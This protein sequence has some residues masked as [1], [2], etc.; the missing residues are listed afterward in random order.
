MGAVPLLVL[1]LGLGVRHATDADHVVVLSTLLQREP[2]VLRATR[3]A[4]LW[5]L[6][7]TA[8]FFTLGVAV[9]L[10]GVKVPETFETVTEALVAAMLIG[11]G[12]FHLAHLLRGWRMPRRSTPPVRGRAGALT[13]ARPVLVG[14]LHGLAG[15]AGVALLA[16]TTI[17]SRAWALAYLALFALGTL[18]GMVALTV[19][20]AWPIGWTLRREGRLAELVGLG[21]SVLSIALG[22]WIVGRALS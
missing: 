20:M 13:L 8:T 22:A 21:S 9:V 2:G 18:V 12:I 6:G 3:L 11:F 16:T 19:L 5:G 17:P 14:V 15:S 1:G 7:H 10:L 4:A